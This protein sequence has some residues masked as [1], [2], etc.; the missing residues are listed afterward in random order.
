MRTDGHQA[1]PHTMQ[2]HSCKAVA[3]RITY[4]R[5]RLPTLVVWQR[6]RSRFADG[7]C[8]FLLHHGV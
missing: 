5:C 8:G 4:E 7:C 6:R 2:S 3:R 1:G